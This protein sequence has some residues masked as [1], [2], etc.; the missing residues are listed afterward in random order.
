MW[1]DL[2]IMDNIVSWNIRGLNWPNKQEDL[3]L[4]LHMNKIGLIGLME[5]K[6]RLENSNKVAARVFPQWRWEN[7]ST[8]SVKGRVWV[9]WHPQIYD[10]QVLQKTDQLIH[11]HA[12]QLSSMNKFYITFVYGMNHADQRQSLWKNLLDISLQMTEAWCILGDFN[13]ILYKEDRLGGNNVLNT[14]I[15]ELADFIDQCDLQELRWDGSYYSWTNKTIW[16]RIDRVF[17]NIH[18]YGVCDFTLTHYKT[19]ALSDHTPL[20]VQFPATPKP[21]HRFQFCD[22]WCGHPDFTKIIDSAMNSIPPPHVTGALRQLKWIMDKICVSLSKPSRNKFADLRSQQEK[23][24]SELES[25]QQKLQ[26]NL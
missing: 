10:L 3:K 16:S 15:K 13:A 2:C 1:W 17:I 6:I 11:C 8:P 22:M 4:F 25:I 26:S 20:L 24:R 7:N 19:N 12:T 18:W 23:A 14:E 21:K 5:T 9:A